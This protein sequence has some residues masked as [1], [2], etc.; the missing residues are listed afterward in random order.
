MDHDSVIGST[1]DRVATFVS[2]GSGEFTINHTTVGSSRG[3]EEEFG[4][5]ALSGVLS[6]TDQEQTATSTGSHSETGVGFQPQALL[7]AGGQYTTGSSALDSGEASLWVGGATG[8]SDEAVAVVIDED[9]QNPTSANEGSSNAAHIWVLDGDTSAT[10]TKKANLTSFDSDGWTS[11]YSV[12]DS[13]A[14]YYVYLALAED[15]ALQASESN[16]V[17][18]AG[19]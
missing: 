3:D 8:A 11:N 10:T 6:N 1:Y 14:D 16:A 17:F 2:F 18:F 9:N 5:V 15:P 12:A 13:F 19:D 7:A 4:Y